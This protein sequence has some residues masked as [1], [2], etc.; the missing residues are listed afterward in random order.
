VFGGGRHVASVLT[1]RCTRR[2]LTRFQATPS[3]E[4]ATPATRLGDWYVGWVPRRRALL[5]FMNERTLLGV[6]VAA[7][8]IATALDR[9]RQ[10]TFDLLVALG[11]GADAAGDEVDAMR[12]VGFAATAN[13]RVL[14][15]LNEATQMMRLLRVD[16][17]PRS[18]FDA[19]L[20]LADTLYSTIGYRHPRDLVREA[21]SPTGTGPRGVH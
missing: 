21:L 15:C 2:V 7:A 19:E 18:L 5:L 17:H 12:D 3:S 16:D 9:W 8:P 13:R 14:G 1:L 11:I 20:Y 6:L 10:S 4:P